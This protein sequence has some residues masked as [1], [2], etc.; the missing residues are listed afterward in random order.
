MPGVGPC[1]HC[2]HV[3]PRVRSVFRCALWTRWAPSPSGCVVAIR[4]RVSYSFRVPHRARTLTHGRTPFGP[5]P[6]GATLPHVNTPPSGTSE[7]EGPTGSTWTQRTH[8][9]HMNPL[10]PRHAPRVRERAAALAGAPHTGPTSPKHVPHLSGTRPGAQS[11]H[12]PNSGRTPG[13]AQGGPLLEWVTPPH[14]P[15]PNHRTPRTPRHTP[16]TPRTPT[17]PHGP[18][19]HT[20]HTNTPLGHARNTRPNPLGHTHTHT[21]TATHRHSHAPRRD[22]RHN[23]LRTPFDHAPRTARTEPE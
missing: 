10:D 21:H 7:H 8:C 12:L 6:R 5:N 1:A 4:G 9:A 22:T 16:R 20:A 15:H 11:L 14:A 23:T 3:C 13:P 18:N 17:E 19:E 2:V